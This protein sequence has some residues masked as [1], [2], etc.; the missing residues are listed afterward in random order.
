MQPVPTR[1]EM[2]SWYP[3]PAPEKRRVRYEVDVIT[4]QRNEIELT[5]EEYRAR[6]VAKII[7]ANEREA[8]ETQRQVSVEKLSALGLT[9]DDIKAL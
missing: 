6:H 3:N 8:R 5:L 7:A 9:P 1:E 2:Q 4:R